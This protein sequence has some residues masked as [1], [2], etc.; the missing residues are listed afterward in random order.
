[1]GTFT[2]SA[3]GAYFG[4]QG[5]FLPC[6]TI[7]DVFANVEAKH[8]DYGVVPVENSTE[9]AV[10]NT[11]DCL[12]DSSLSIVGEVVV[13]IV[14]HLLVSKELANIAEIE[15]VASHKQSLAQCR[16]WLK[17]HF[18]NTS[19][20]EVSSNAQAAK[21]A[22][23]NSSIAAIAGS[24]AA[25]MYGLTI[26]HSAI[27][28]KPNNST[29]FLVLA[30]K[31]KATSPSGMDKTSLLIY[32]NNEPGALFRIL[33]PFEELGI[34]LSKIETRPSKVEAWEYVFFVDFDGHINDSLVT[35]L[36]SRLKLC[37]AEIK[38]LGSYAKFSS[39]K[40]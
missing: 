3:A 7:D 25:E 6:S 11:Q 13:P 9:G 12:I 32:T 4:D 15:Q 39:K 17:N 20:V 37:T 30:D 28:D 34:S 24:M 10:N 14:H 22:S 8:S 1:M 36:F 23:E 29:R 27:Q 21:L 38:I 18:P 16:N 26:Q 31:T 33:Q 2:Q 40:Q 19:L 5:D 35:E